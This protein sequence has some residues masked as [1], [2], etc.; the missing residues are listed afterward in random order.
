[1]LI[2][3]FFVSVVGGV[4]SKAE[5]R[6]SAKSQ[7]RSRV[8][9]STRPRGEDQGVRQGVAQTDVDTVLV[10][11]KVVVVVVVGSRTAR[12]VGTIIAMGRYWV[13]VSVEESEI[14]SLGGVVYLNKGSV[15]AYMPMPDSKPNTD[16]RA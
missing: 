12:V 9:S 8:R 13:V 11:K 7:S 15:V 10:G 6:S 16:T 1:L 4:V 2:S 14:E 3:W 5:S